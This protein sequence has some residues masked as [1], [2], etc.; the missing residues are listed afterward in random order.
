M[1]IRIVIAFL[2]ISQTFFAGMLLKDYDKASRGT[3]KTLYAIL[4]LATL[5]FL[6]YALAD[7]GDECFVVS[8]LNGYSAYADNNYKYSKDGFGNVTVCFGVE[9]G[10]VSGT[11]AKFIK[12]GKSTLVGFGGNKKGNEL[13]EV[14]QLDRSNM[15]MLYTKSR[16]GTKSVNTLFSDT[17]SSSVGHAKRLN[18]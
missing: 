7:I 16:I 18:E 8:N 3:M 15:K 5:T 12:F 9:S 17:V 6:P 10:T 11:D 14:Y 1:K 4:I 2:L 13:I